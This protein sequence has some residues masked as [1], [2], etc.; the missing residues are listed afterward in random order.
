MSETI[1]KTEFKAHALAVLRD[2]EQTGEARVITD[3]GTPT[4]EIRK[5]R[6]EDR[7][8]LEKL[9]DSVVSF[10]RPTEPVAENDWDLLS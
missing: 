7:S 4:L 5:L 3:R 2:I 9:C 1:S 10:S 6:R 8:P